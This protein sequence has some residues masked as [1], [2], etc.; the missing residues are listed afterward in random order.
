MYRIGSWHTSF[1][2][3]FTLQQIH[4]TTTSW[5][6]TSTSRRC[7]R[8][9]LKRWVSS[10]AHLT[11]WKLP[12]ASPYMHKHVSRWMPCLFL[13]WWIQRLNARL[14]LFVDMPISLC[15]FH[16]IQC[17]LSKKGQGS[18]CPVYRCTVVLPLRLTWAW[19]LLSGL[20]IKLKM[21]TLA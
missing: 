10:P 12:S 20:K 6:T 4:S 2:S 18:N 15:Y 5:R 3:V 8:R 9:P 19:F 21:L 14:S 1:L 7:L 11:Q 17:E 16:Q 13:W